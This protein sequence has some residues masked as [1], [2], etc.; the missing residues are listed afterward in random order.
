MLPLARRF[1]HPWAPEY[2]HIQITPWS[3]CVSRSF[4]SQDI[5][6]FDTQIAPGTRLSPPPRTIS[7]GYRKP[8]VLIVVDDRDVE[9]H[10]AFEI[11]LKAE[12]A[13]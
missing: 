1:F 11:E 2:G 9:L 8:L 7:M 12:R 4:S 6:T 3:V 10:E 13:R 5:L